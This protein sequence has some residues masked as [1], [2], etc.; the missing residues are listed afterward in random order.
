MLIMSRAMRDEDGPVVARRFYERLFESETI[1]TDA[2]A[3]ALDE[4]VAALRA[5]GAPADRWATFVHM[6]A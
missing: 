4:A 3:Y 2:V 1:D 6:G 5:S